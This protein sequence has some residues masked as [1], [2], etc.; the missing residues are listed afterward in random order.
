MDQKQIHSKKIGFIGC[1][2]LAQAM[3]GALIETGMPKQQIFATNRTPGKL[4]KIV[5]QTG[6]RGLANNEHLVEQSDVVILAM[7]PQD[8]VAAVEPLA[9]SFNASHLVISLAAGIEMPRL[10]K[11]LPGVRLWA[12]VMPNTPVRIRQGVSGC[13][14]AKET[15]PYRGLVESLLDP[16]GATIFVE[17]EELLTAISVASAAGVGFVFE[18][19]IYWQE[20]LEEHGFSPEQARLITTKTFLG[21]ALLADQSQQTSF[22]ELQ[23]RVTS[24]KGITAAGLDSM[25]ELEVER[26]LRYSFEK[27][28]L[29]NQEISKENE[30]T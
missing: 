2:H 21:A 29:R 15:S 5:E 1:G 6:I 16:L 19:F 18:L 20:W 4:N 9:N 30:R 13:F 23:N 3:I 8:L 17:E 25:R 28:A 22:D 24:K 11:L 12:R 27:S 14:L 7:K 10:K 26:L